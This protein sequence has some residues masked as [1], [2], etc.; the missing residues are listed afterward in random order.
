MR[1]LLVILLLLSSGTIFAQ[2]PKL[3]KLEMLYDQG[4]YGIV[5]RRANRLLDN[6]EFDFSLLPTYYRSLAILQ[7]SQQERW[8]NRH[9]EAY[10]V[11]LDDL[12]KIKNSKK[13]K[14]ILDAHLFEIQAL[15]Q[16]MNAWI[17]DLKRLGRKEEA[18]Q[19]AAKVNQFFDGFKE[20][21][22]KE[23][24]AV[25]YSGEVASYLKN[26]ASMVTFA[27]QYLGVP[28][29]SAGE[30]PTGFDCSGF[31]S[32]IFSNQQIKLPRR[33]VD[34]YNSSQKIKESEAM[35]GDLIFF[36]NGG[37]ISH[38]GMLINEPGKPITMI[39]ASS[40]KGISIVEIESSAYWKSRVVG[41]GRYLKE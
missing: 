12:I 13:G 25:N 7:L 1:L 21:E 39:H 27:Q 6:P 31:T 34:Q 37:D 4:H 19:I 14:L 22:D 41:Y 8:R 3:D 2:V 32:Y 36:S 20:W 35:M 40:S 24:K 10:L 9:P 11:A 23:G 17:S 26:R 16:D 28:Y 30:S 29:V 15:Q 5:Y 33:A 38:V 18:T